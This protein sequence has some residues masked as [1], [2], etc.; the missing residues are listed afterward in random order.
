MTQ[1]NTTR[2]SLGELARMTALV[3]I[4]FAAFAVSMVGLWK[5]ADAAFA[6]AF[7]VLIAV[8]FDAGARGLG[9]LVPWNRRLRVLIIILLSFALLLGAIYWGGTRVVS[10]ARSLAG[11]MQGLFRH[12]VTVMHHESQ[13][14]LPSGDDSLKQIPGLDMIVGRATTLIRRLFESVIFFVVALFVGAFC[15]WEP[16]VYKGAFL[17]LLPREHR[18]R[19][20][21]V[22]DRSAHA[23]RSWLVGRGITMA[24]IFVF[25][26][27]ALTAIKMPNSIVLAMQAGLFTFTPT[28]GPFV[29][30][31]VI[32]LA[33]LAQS[34]S[35][36]LY[37]LVT[38][39]LVQSLE[40]HV[41]TPL[42]QRRTIR[43]PPAITLAL[44][45]I[46]AVLFGLIAAV[47]I[48]PLAA[49]GKV[50]IEELYVNDRLGGGWQVGAAD[51]PG[52]DR[53][54]G[55]R[56]WLKQLRWVRRPR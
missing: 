50:F 22:M 49:A 35:M 17:S 43:I 53:T 12:A 56:E 21:E 47:V 25:T 20:S 28:L 14:W 11:Q 55:L 9:Y 29:A 46:A 6:V 33:G 5:A 24:L 10:E 41:I 37:G 34:E 13:A 19:V 8:T 4:I 1:E 40:S 31:V 27:C 32:V 16:E 44:Q 23:L 52:R 48:I 54:S 39:V 18:P 3:V 42:V 26:L 30:G 7:G 15:A 2:R 45:L 51:E 36:A 38:Y